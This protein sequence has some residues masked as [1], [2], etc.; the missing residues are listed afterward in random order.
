MCIR[1]R[2]EVESRIIPDSE[3]TLPQVEALNS[4]GMG[5]ATNSNW[6]ATGGSDSNDEIYEMVFDSQGNVIICG[7]IYQVSQF[8]SIIVNTEGEGDI[9]MA[10]LSK[11]G[12]WVWAVSAGTALYYDEC[13]GVTVDSND[14]IYGTGYFRGQ[15]NFGNTTV[16]TTGFD[17]WIARVNSTG[18]FDWAMKFG[19]FDIDVGL[20]L[21][22]I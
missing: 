22:H 3:L 2:P 17:G 12:S 18:Q 1:D 13:R 10:K 21:I 8:G 20:S 16:S 19:G 7:S 15:V 5:R 11:T 9:L 6:S 4:I 14:N